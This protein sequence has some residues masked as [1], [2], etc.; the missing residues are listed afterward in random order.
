M[1][2]L[3]SVAALVLLAFAAA[4]GA[5]AQNA[6]DA[7]KGA[8]GAIT[9]GTSSTISAGTWTYTGPGVSFKSKNAL[10]NLG[11]AAAGTAIEAKLKP[12]YDKLGLQNMTFTVAEDS[13]YTMKVKKLTFKGKIIYGEKGECTLQMQGLGK[14]AGGSYKAQW[15][16]TGNTLLLTFDITKL[17]AIIEKIAN[18][19]GKS[20]LQAVSK[21]LKSYDGIYAGFRFSKQK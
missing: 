6:L 13:T 15:Q 2:K 7:L 11:G 20:S 10:Q 21:V 5:G 17:V 4:P 16:V 18:V 8:L 1:R 19:S 9:G 3:L 14:I 12:Y